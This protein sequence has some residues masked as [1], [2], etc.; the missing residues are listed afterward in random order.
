MFIEDVRSTYDFERS[1]ELGEFGLS[2]W[3]EGGNLKQMNNS[4]LNKAE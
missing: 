1:G 2:E 3:I 4:K